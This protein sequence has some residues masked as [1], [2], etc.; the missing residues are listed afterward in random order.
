M[1]LVFRTTTKPFSNTVQQPPTVFSSN[2][3]IK[4]LNALL[5]KLSFAGNMIDRVKSSG[6]PCGSCG[7]R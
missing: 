6:E 7:G 2:S 3:S 4:N 1:K 5:T